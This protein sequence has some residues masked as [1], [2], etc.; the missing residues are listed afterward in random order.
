M[1]ESAPFGQAV[2]PV[3]EKEKKNQTVPLGPHTFFL[4]LSPGP[5]EL[6]IIEFPHPREANPP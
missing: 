2:T 3:P 1:R 4:P 5:A 6:L